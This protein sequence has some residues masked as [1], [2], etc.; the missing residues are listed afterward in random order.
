MATQA[1]QLA[2][3]GLVRIYQYTLSPLLHLIAPGSGCRYEPSCSEYTALAIRKHGPLR[4]G[5][6]GVKRIA[7]CHPWGGHGIDPVPE[8]C[9][10]S[11]QHDPQH[12]HLSPEADSAR[13]RKGH[14]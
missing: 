9:A 6:L 14:P 13:A 10:C 2:L 11:A 5:W 12:P 8:T 3:I 7:R 1:A 4:G